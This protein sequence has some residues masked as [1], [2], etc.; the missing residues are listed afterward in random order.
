MPRLEPQRATRKFGIERFGVLITLCQS[1]ANLPSRGQAASE[2]RLRTGA[3]AV[4]ALVCGACGGGSS[5]SGVEQPSG[6]GSGSVSLSWAVPTA[7]T[8]GSAL[9]DV[10]GYLVEYGGSAA[11]LNQSIAVS[12]A[13]RTTATVSGLDAGTHYFA[14]RTL[15][16]VGAASERSAVV[17]K[18]VP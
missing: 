15:N 2:R 1:V 10:T 3:T 8:D 16:A 9:T 7:N 6:G 13:A 18:T 11:G 17:S 4:I 12:G 5:S 14:V